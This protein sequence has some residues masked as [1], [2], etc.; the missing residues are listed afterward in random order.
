[1]KPICLVT[2]T[3][4]LVV[5]LTPPAYADGEQDR[6]NFNINERT[7]DSAIN[8]VAQ[9]SKSPAIF[10]FNE[11]LQLDAPQLKGNYTTEEA[12]SY[13]L[14]GTGLQANITA[15]GVITIMTSQAQDTHWEETNTMTTNKR[16]LMSGAAAIGAV[17]API[18]ASAQTPAP[19]ESTSRYALD[20]IVVTS[21]R[22]E[23]S[24]Q[25][26]PIAV[27]AISGVELENRGALDVID[28]ADVAPNVSMKTNGSVSGFA[29][30][31]RTSIRGIGQSDFVINTDPAVG[32]YADGVYLG[33]SIGSVLDLVDVERVEA[34]R[35]PQGTLFGRNSTGGAINIISK[36]PDVGGPQSGYVT[37]AIG[38]GGYYLLRGSAN[39][40][41]NENAAV[42][43][44][45]LK[46]AR[47]GFVPLLNPVYNDKF[48]LGAEDV[49]GLKAAFR[50]EPTDTFTLDLDADISSRSDSAAPI[51]AVDFGD[52]SVGL[53]GLD[54]VSN[55]SST[56][57]H[58]RRFN[59]EGFT[60]AQLNNAAAFASTVADG[61]ADPLIRD[62]SSACLGD[63]YISSRDGS[64]ATWF[65]ND[66]NQIAADDQALDTYGFSARLMWE[67]ENL[68]ISTISS[69][70]GFDAD[71]INGSPAPIY[72]A[73]NHNVLFEQDQMSHEINFA[74]N[75]N[76]RISWLGGLFY[77]EEDGLEIVEVR[78]PLAPPPSTSGGL[79]LPLA[80]TSDRFIDNTSA[81]V[82]GQVAAQITDRLELTLGARQ[83]EESKEVLVNSASFAVPDVETVVALTA[84]AR[85]AS[86]TNVLAN[87]SF[88]VTDDAMVYLQYSD[89]FRN[90]GFPA[91]T[92]GMFN[93]DDFVDLS[94]GEETVDSFEIGSK[95]T[96]LDG[97]LRVNAAAFKMDYS[98][99]Q[100]TATAFV[101]ALGE[102]VP[103]TANV[104][105]ATIQGIE[106]EGSYLATDNLR[107]DF[108]LGYLDTELTSINPDDAGVRQFILGAGTNVQKTI[109]EDS[110]VELPHAPELQFNLGANYSLFMDNGA[111]IRN[112]ADIIYEAEQFGTLANYEAGLIPSTTRLNYNA[113]Y[114]PR[115][116]KWE[117]TLGARNLTNEEDISN[118]IVDASPRSGIY[119]VLAR[120]R[121][122]YLQFKYNFGE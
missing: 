4:C 112:R 19:D 99:L 84:P 3:L 11:V 72:S 111:E 5:C 40:P 104:G 46:R 49:T 68:T 22:V 106:L 75:I 61:C 89:G 119:H 44:N 113:T 37:A 57:V 81:A 7:I 117:F 122:A 21:R 82:Y 45:V 107:F 67:L 56:S 69:W 94:Y 58:A 110:G 13:I 2:A 60:P 35:G 91:R 51:V 1:M 78:Y 118:A 70:R 59:L 115:H 33:R 92:P 14:E 88:D 23:E 120:G 83:T 77:Q 42:L 100:V 34:L 80:N 85:E 101:P 63:Y 8:A 66:N 86:E 27:T 90:G 108:S 103:A 31:P 121:E 52:L 54:N 16:L 71:F 43:V 25:S 15:D 98:D 47:N 79:L 17:V 87:L 102:T 38:E 36:K 93:P 65:D 74:G 97:A 62:T 30:A 32:L 76:D 64:W 105:D 28:F 39:L 114:I 18:Q 12:L 53:S 96:F 109:T 9:Q 6:Y 73:T 48:E 41:I 55:G 20:D 95:S 24:L 26:A 116:A 10:S 50:W 29:A